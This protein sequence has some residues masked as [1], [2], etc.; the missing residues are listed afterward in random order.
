M[1]ADEEV[2]AACRAF[3]EPEPHD[4]GR[5]RGWDDLAEGDK[6]KCRK[7]MR[8]ALEAAERVRSR[9]K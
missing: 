5:T 1:I 4:F 9:G 8:A 7:W 6:E 2:E 3:H